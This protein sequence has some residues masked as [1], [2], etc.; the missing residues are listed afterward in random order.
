MHC[1]SYFSLTVP[2]G[3]ALIRSSFPPALIVCPTSPSAEELKDAVSGSGSGSGSFPLVALVSL[4]PSVV[5]CFCAPV[6][7]LVQ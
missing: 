5:I 2:L 1:T 3:R 4:F 6:N 7:S